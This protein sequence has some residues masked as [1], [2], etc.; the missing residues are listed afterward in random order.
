M[1]FQ[2]CGWYGVYCT[3]QLMHAHLHCTLHSVV[4]A[5]YNVQCTVYTVSCTMYD[6][7][8]KIDSA[9]MSR[10]RSALEKCSRYAHNSYRN[11]QRT[12]YSVC[13]T[14]YVVQATS[15]TVRR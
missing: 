10:M 9:C 4:N 7:H 12:K 15:Y 5:V 2:E 14:I 3:I 6:V 11:E 1:F 8:F 13:R